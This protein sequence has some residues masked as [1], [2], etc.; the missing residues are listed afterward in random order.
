MLLA[1]MS[2]S[3]RDFGMALERE[4]YKPRIIVVDRGFVFVALCPDL[5]G[6]ALHYECI[7]SRCIRTWGTS[8]GLAQLIKGPTEST[9]F[10]AVIERQVIPV[11]A[12]LFTI[13]VD[14]ES[15]KNIF[16]IVKK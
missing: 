14:E 1:H 16:P 3:V 6:V 5:T 2:R 12:I 4:N 10:D 11:R 7:N 8:E 15:W 9:V 13:D